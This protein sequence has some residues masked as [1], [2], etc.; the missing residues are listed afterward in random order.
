[1]NPETVPVSIRASLEKPST[2][3]K[4]EIITFSAK[5]R[6]R[7][8]L[9]MLGICWGIAVLCVPLPIIH[10]T[11]LPSLLV[12]GVVMFIRIS[13]QESLVLGGSG[14]CPECG[15]TFAIAKATN[16]FPMDEMCEHCKANVT[17]DRA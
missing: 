13:G 12:A 5:E 14:P 8:A 11:V 3:G 16:R 17:I 15:K 10:F 7:R 6:S 2:T 4:V 9:K 1:M